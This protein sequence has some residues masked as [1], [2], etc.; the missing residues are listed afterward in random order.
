VKINFFE[1][2][3]DLFEGTLYFLYNILGSAVTLLR[4]PFEGPGQL[5]AARTA[6]KAAPKDGPRPGPQV[7]GLAFL[8]IYLFAAL[9]AIDILPGG[10]IQLRSLLAIFGEPGEIG[11]GPAWPAVLGALAA[12]A[13]VDASA[14]LLILLIHLFSRDVPAAERDGL[15]NRFEYALFWPLFLIMA[16]I[17]LLVVVGPGGAGTRMP[18][19]WTALLFAGMAVIYFSYLPAALQIWP[20]LRHPA[21]GKGSNRL[22]GFILAIGLVTAIL[23][24]AVVCGLGVAEAVHRADAAAGS[25]GQPGRSR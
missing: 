19:W 17:G 13:L 3:E 9:L 11:V 12:A 14:R 1:L 16:L 18:A 25:D 7:G 2:F 24:S 22:L 21:S 15:V 5:Y 6:Y 20:N 8:F 10:A 23:I 4:H